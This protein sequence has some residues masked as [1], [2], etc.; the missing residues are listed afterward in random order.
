MPGFLS[1][2]TNQFRLYILYAAATEPEFNLENADQTPLNTKSNLSKVHF[3]KVTIENNNKA[4]CS[5]TVA[6]INLPWHRSGTQKFTFKSSY[7]PYTFCLEFAFK[8]V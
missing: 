5:P 4:C 6:E 1:Y 3:S 7:K 8:I 2:F